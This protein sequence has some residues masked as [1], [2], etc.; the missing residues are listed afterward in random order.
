MHMHGWSE[1][2]SRGHVRQELVQEGHSMKP[3]GTFRNPTLSLVRRIMHINELM[4]IN[5]RS[6]D[7]F[8][9][10]IRRS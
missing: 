5:E 6:R 3:G 1:T 8:M 9:L 7:Y 4:Y 10:D 2:W